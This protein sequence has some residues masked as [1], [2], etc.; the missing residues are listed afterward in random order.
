MSTESPKS[1]A[2]WFFI[3]R[4]HRLAYLLVPK[5]ASTS[6]TAAML[7]LNHPEVPREQAMDEEWLTEASRL[8]D[9]VL[10]TNDSL[11]GYFRFTFVR[12][13]YARF[14]SF[15][16]NKIGDVT[17]DT[18]KPRFA[19]MGLSA[20]MDMMAVLDV[21]EAIPRN[22]LDPHII[23]QCHYIFGPKGQRVEFVGRFEQIDEGMNTVRERSRAPLEIGQLNATG[24]SAGRDP[25]EGLPEALRARLAQFYKED[26]ERFGYE[27]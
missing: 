17:P 5:A 13:P 20:G 24:S 2:I 26:F 7:L 1:T 9:K 19:K 3:S 6:L 23:P 8:H 16:R 12:N 18:L 14:V 11:K 15:Y 4:R 22:Q 27:M 10:A 21:V 25:R